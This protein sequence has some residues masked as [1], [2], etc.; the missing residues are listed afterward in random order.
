[1]AE[2]VESQISGSSLEQNQAPAL[3]VLSVSSWKQLLTWSP[4]EAKLELELAWCCNSECRPSGGL[5]VSFEQVGYV[6]FGL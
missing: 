4:E 3:G 6:G 1:M 2:S 5:G